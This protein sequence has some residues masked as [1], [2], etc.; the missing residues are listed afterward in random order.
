[1]TTVSG[2][3]SGEFIILS[4]G[5]SRVLDVRKCGTADGTV[6]IL[7]P[8]KERSLDEHSR[9]RWNDNQ[10]FFVDEL[11]ALIGKQSR[12]LVDIQDGQLVIDSRKPGKIYPKFSYSETTKQI[13]I[14]LPKSSTVS[15]EGPSTDIETHALTF[16][17]KSNPRAA[18]DDNGV[19]V[20]ALLPPD[21]SFIDHAQDDRHLEHGAPADGSE[22]DSLYWKRIPKISKV[23]E[24]ESGDVIGE[25]EILRRL[26]EVI[27]IRSD[28][29]GSEA[30]PRMTV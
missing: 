13:T 21:G 27:P 17:P 10:V 4:L 15:G 3:P 28:D 25:K 23:S 11:G 12:S 6:L 1:M 29:K 20:T 8:C 9:D 18:F 7:Y 2:F 30:S 22:D 24:S 16:H 19:L 14:E 26:W 5:S